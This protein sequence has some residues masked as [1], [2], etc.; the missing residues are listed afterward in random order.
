[1]VKVKNVLKGI[2]LVGGVGLMVKGLVDINKPIEYPIDR[3]RPK[4]VREGIQRVKEAIVEPTYIKIDES[5]AYAVAARV[6]AEHLGSLNRILGVDVEGVNLNPQEDISFLLNKSILGRTWGA[7]HCRRGEDGKNEYVGLSLHVKDFV[8]MSYLDL[9]AF[10]KAVIE[11]L[12]HEVRHAW[13]YKT[14]AYYDNQVFYIDEDKNY[15]LRLGYDESWCELDANA[16]GHWYVNN[17]NGST[18]DFIQPPTD[19]EVT[20]Y[21]LRLEEHSYPLYSRQC[22]MPTMFR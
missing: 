7:C 20:D 8:G 9:K 21:Q 18:A 14:G 22:K 2:C 4:N 5:T 12:A 15:R 11:I 1:M 6:V 10:E 17:L 19:H 16:F 13:Q 3:P